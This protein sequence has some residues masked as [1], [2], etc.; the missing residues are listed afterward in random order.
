MRLRT[1][2]G[3]R[4]YLH[5]WRGGQAYERDKGA[6][7][8]SE[9]NNLRFSLLRQ[10]PGETDILNGD[11]RDPLPFASQVF[12]A[13][14]A[15]H[16]VEHLTPE[17]ARG[18]LGEVHRVTKPGAIVRLST[19]DL[20]GNCRAYLARLAELEKDP[21]ERAL[22]RYEWALL[23]L[24][25]Q[26]VRTRPGGRMAEFKRAG[27]F[28]PEYTRERF[29]DVF[30]EFD[31]AG[32]ES[33]I[34]ARG[35]KR[36]KLFTRLRRGLLRRIAANSDPETAAVHAALRDANRMRRSGE[37]NLWLYDRLSLRMLLEESGFVDVEQMTY[38]TSRIPEWE[39]FD[40]DRSSHGEY[41]FEPSLY[42]EVRRGG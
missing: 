29:G 32:G 12:D 11:V 21:T 38:A 19:P 41:P 2:K 6:L 25:D 40:F 30:D 15:F 4:T 13:V 37:A 39:R 18:F 7:Y 14:Y 5:L 1:T 17:E 34:A 28:D 26:M 3:G 35:Q 10:P 23:E 8:R 16:I 22:L 20:E 33:G 36:Q 42:M 27:R 9:W 24:F 31:G